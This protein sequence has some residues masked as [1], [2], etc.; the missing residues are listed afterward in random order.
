MFY[1][2]LVALCRDRG[3]SVTGACNNA[4]IASTQ[5]PRL[6]EVCETTDHCLALFCT[7]KRPEGR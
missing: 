5:V 1:D 7:Q 4:G 3:E 2:K 6:R